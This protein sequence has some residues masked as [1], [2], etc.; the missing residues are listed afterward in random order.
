[1]KAGGLL[2][3][4]HNEGMR[5]V[6]WTHVASTFS[7]I[8]EATASLKR[9]KVEFSVSLLQYFPTPCARYFLLWERKFIPD[10]ND[11]D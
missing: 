6:N 11:L 2:M 4:G 5:Y 9:A 8:F 7:C 3:M 10:P 1:M